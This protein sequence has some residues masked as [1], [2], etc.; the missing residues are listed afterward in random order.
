MSWMF[1]AIQGITLIWLW[2]RRY[3]R[4]WFMAA[5]ALWTVQ[6]VNVSL[7][8]GPAWID[9]WWKWPE[10]ALLLAT[11]A[12]VVETKACGTRYVAR[13]FQRLQIRI[14]AAAL[15]TCAVGIGVFLIPPASFQ[16]CRMWVWWGLALALIVGELLMW[17]E[18]VKRPRM[19][20]A[21]SL[22]LL[23]VMFAHAIICPRP[24]PE[25]Y[26]H[27]ILIQWWSL[28]AISRTLIGCCCVG[29]A[30]L[31]LIPAGSRPTSS[32]RHQSVG[33]ERVHA[34]SGA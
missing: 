23:T 14:A 5:L 33:A 34:Q 13:P 7:P 18:S 28:Q 27:F 16:E 31:P 26:S 11:V 4:P 10:I 3:P 21:H 12:S 24:F 25:K 8:H 15:P 17:L 1:T 9:T 2:V 22:L 19:V 29:W 20:A 30:I 6:S 32:A